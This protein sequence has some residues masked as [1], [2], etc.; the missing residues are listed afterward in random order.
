MRRGS[1]TFGQR[2]HCDS[3]RRGAGDFGNAEGFWAKALRRVLKPHCSLIETASG[4]YLPLNWATLAD[5]QFINAYHYARTLARGDIEMSKE[6]SQTEAHNLVQVNASF[7]NWRNGNGGV[8]DHPAPTAQWTIVRNSA[9]IIPLVRACPARLC[10]AP[11][12][13]QG[14]CRRGES[15]LAS[16]RIRRGWGDHLG[17]P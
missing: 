12:N 17:F 16:H 11:T 5:I 15:Y 6:H 10:Q 1:Q 8:F 7:E 4:V 14:W 13:T 3:E 2:F 9:V